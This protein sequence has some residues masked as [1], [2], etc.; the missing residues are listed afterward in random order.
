[1]R[2]IQFN[3]FERVAGMFVV[4][5]FFGFIVSLVGVAVKQGW[6]DRKIY[7]TTSF[8]SGDGVHPGTVVQIQ[9]LKAGTVE[10]VELDREN[11]VQVT[12]YILGKFENKVRQDSVAQL[13]RPFVIGERILDVSVGSKD[14]PLLPPNQIMS[15]AETVDLLSLLSGK[16]LGNS[17]KAMSGMMESLKTLATA[18]LDKNRTSAFINAF[19]R[20]DPLL[21]NL[22]TM[23]IEVIK[24]AKQAT[25]D[26]QLEVVLKELAITTRE[27]NVLVPELNKQAPDLAKDITSLVKNLS[28]LTDEFKVVLPALAEVAPDLPR[29]SRRALEALD[30]AVVL[31]K[32]MEK[33]FFVKGNAE[34]VRKEEAERDRKR[35]QN[36][37]PAGKE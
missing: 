31:I 20:I 11:R 22:N 14:A 34:E 9:G 24:L 3:K 27:L 35:Q 32:A 25:K 36:R 7:W 1:M 33:S 29:A 28:V 12:F 30:E 8:I 23:S 37:V 18:F 4:A 13:I 10:S 16:E 5:S 15:S 6:F 19:D 26:Q 2:R 21:K 17:I